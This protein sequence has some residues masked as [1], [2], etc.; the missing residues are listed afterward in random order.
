MKEG[1]QG[2]AHRP[3]DILNHLADW[4]EPR[5]LSAS[6]GEIVEAIYALALGQL[7]PAEREQLTLPARRWTLEASWARN[8]IREQSRRP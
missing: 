2:D 6:T 4:L 8:D 1:P 3:V 7:D 5:R